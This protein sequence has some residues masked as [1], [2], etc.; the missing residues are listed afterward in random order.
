MSYS[1][2][3]DFIRSLYLGDIELIRSEDSDEK[4][5]LRLILSEQNY[6]LTF[7]EALVNVL[8]DRRQ[9]PQICSFDSSRFLFG[10]TPFTL[11]Y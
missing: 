5:A 2:A 3:K 11:P 6:D 7:E 1:I 9:I 4:S 8:A 10:I